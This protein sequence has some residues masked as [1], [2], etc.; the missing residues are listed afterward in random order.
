[1][2]SD[3]VFNAIEVIASKPGKKDK[4]ALVKKLM[5][6]LTARKVLLSAYDPYTTYG[7]IK[8]PEKKIL[9]NKVF[10]SLTWMLLEQLSKRKLTGHAARD[11]IQAEMDR[12][13]DTSAELLKR[14][15]KRD[16][17]AGFTDGTINRVR[18]GTFAEFPYM[19]CVLPKSAKL[20]K[21]NW[22]RG[23][24]SQVKADG[25][26]AN[27]NV[28]SD[29]SVSIHSRQ[30]T[31]YPIDHPAFVKMTSEIQRL[32]V[33]GSQSHGEML[34]VGPDGKDLS[35]Q[36]GN[37]MINKV[38]QGGELPK[39]HYIRFSVWDQ[40]PLDCAVPDGKYEVSYETRIEYLRNQLVHAKTGLV[41]L[42]ETEV[43]HSIQEA[44]EHSARCRARGFEGS[45]IK[46]PVGFWKDSSSGSKDVVKLKLEVEI[47]VKVVG[48]TIGN[49]ARSHLFGALRVQSS[50]GLF[51]CDVGTGFSEDLLSEINDMG[52]DVLDMVATIKIN[53]IMY[54]S[55][56]NPL[57][58]A[59][60]PV[61]IELRT[62]KN[63]ADSLR[64][65]LDQVNA[66]KGIKQ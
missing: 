12:L 3:Q 55:D 6:D 66:A 31:E 61:F 62:D 20:D 63:V 8:V 21:W 16:L 47:D 26:F 15:I 39:D 56:S 5:E 14:I 27:V 17:R 13:S 35:R 22:V 29:N 42:I 60:L 57:H 11:S 48:K 36:L 19:R 4:E 40:I 34:V 28:H 10:S 50:D 65:I 2:N 23:V 53:D 44:Y 51:A 24:Y 30:G 41:S 54:P 49:G 52:D 37:G 45:V 9:G 18:P 25:M 58:S 64:K 46:N 59:F 32:F 33:P 38:Q 43:V 7:V 1:M